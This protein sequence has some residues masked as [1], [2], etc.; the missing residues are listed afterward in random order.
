[1]NPEYEIKIDG[2]T[3]SSKPYQAFGVSKFLFFEPKWILTQ[4][5]QTLIETG[6]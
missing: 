1:M 6:I 4:K 2:L 3:R 5:C